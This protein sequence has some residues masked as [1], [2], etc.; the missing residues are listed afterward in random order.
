MTCYTPHQA[1][2]FAEQIALNRSEADV[3]GLIPSMSQ[4]KKALDFG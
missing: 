2:Y 1:R 4:S 3:N